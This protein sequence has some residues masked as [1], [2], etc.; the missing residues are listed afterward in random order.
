[1]FC[2]GAPKWHQVITKK[3]RIWEA[4]FPNY[5]DLNFQHVC[6]S[7][8]IAFTHTQ[9]HKCLNLLWSSGFPVRVCQCCVLADLFVCAF[10]CSMSVHLRRPSKKTRWLSWASVC[11]SDMMRGLSLDWPGGRSRP[12]MAEQQAVASSSTLSLA[13]PFFPWFPSNWQVDK[14]RTVELTSSTHMVGGL[15]IGFLICLTSFY[16]KTGVGWYFVLTLPFSSHA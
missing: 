13:T 14:R 9:S 8:G 15:H 1:M 11:T 6:K 2:S 5:T 7:V 10:A 16:N 12:S 4:F 3:E